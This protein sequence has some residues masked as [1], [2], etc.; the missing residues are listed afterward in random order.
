MSS[1]NE[2]YKE[3]FDKINIS[4]DKSKKVYN[5]ILKKTGKFSLLRPVFISII[6]ILCIV[7]IGAVYAKDIS[8]ALNSF[9]ITKK[10]DEKGNIRIETHSSAR[11]EINYDANLPEVEIKDA[12]DILT[13]NQYSFEE[14]EDLLNIK[15][16]RSKFFKNDKLVQIE[17]KKVD[18]KIA[19]TSFGLQN[20][21][22]VKV[23]EGQYGM[24]FCIITKY[25]T[26]EIEKSKKSSFGEKNRTEL[27]YIKSIG[28]EALIIK[29]VLPESKVQEWRIEFDYSEIH[30]SFDLMFVGLEPEEMEIKTIEILESLS[31]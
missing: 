21:T 22:N 1:L 9:I 24:A 11:P 28:T 25:A 23:E 8:S 14:L 12:N 29:G 17:T 6:I 20:F 3:T 31:N 2:K 27:Y 26:E 13:H 16:L 30:Y 18:N 10:H 15:I 5:S 19:Y 7:G 4:D